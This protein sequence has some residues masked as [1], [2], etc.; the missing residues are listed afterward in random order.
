M[1]VQ[2]SKSNW[3]AADASGD[4]KLKRDIL[5]SEVAKLI[6]NNPKRVTDRLTEVGVK[7]NGAPNSKL[8][9]KVVS[10][11]MLNSP[12]FAKAIASDIVS[13]YGTPSMSSDGDAGA[14]QKV[15]PEQAAGAASTIFTM[16]GNVFGGKH[17]DKT[18]AQT[19]NTAAQSDLGTHVK[20]VE[21]PNSGASHV[22]RNITIALVIAL[23]V[24]GIVLVARSK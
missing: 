17:K 7:V 4:E 15:S 5:M 3:S 2:D 23:A 10:Q 13:G 8:L 21:D 20:T 12:K 19:T 18:T 16:F 24:T 14:S 9:T 1:L 22:G 6:V 11:T